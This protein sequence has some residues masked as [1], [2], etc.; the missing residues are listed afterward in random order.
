MD[1]VVNERSLKQL[2]ETMVLSSEVIKRNKDA[3][4]LEEGKATALHK[5]IVE[6]KGEISTLIRQEESS[7]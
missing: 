7:F 3:M 4:L 5:D 6:L 2:R 1:I